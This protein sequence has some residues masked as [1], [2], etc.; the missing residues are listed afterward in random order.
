MG[1]FVSA[2]LEVVDAWLIVL[3]ETRILGP[4]L[5]A[6]MIAAIATIIWRREYK[7]RNLE[8]ATMRAKL[9]FS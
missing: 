9:P 7:S 5:G 8:T 4:A 1:N 6:A 3:P 2:P